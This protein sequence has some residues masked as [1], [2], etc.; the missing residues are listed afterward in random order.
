MGNAIS[1]KSVGVTS[2]QAS[3][4]V[5]P[6]TPLPIGFVTPLQLGTQGTGIFQM[7]Y[8][9]ADQVKDNLRNLILTNWGERVCQYNFG[10]NL[11]Q[12]TT[13]LVSG[14]DFETEVIVRIK[15]AV[16]TWMPHVS[17]NDFQMV[18]DLSQNNETGVISFIITYDV[19]ALS[20]KNAMLEITMYVL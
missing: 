19:P 16:S 13:E 12:L 6:T 3:A 4:R 5:L 17:L 1:F 18:T 8:D 20:V 10:A 14:Q 2:Q 7:H 11:R 15:T 9:L